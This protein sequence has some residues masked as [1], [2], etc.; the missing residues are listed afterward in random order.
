M[1]APS[2]D[3]GN[4]GSHQEFEANLRNSSN[5]LLALIERFQYFNEHFNARDTDIANKD[6]DHES[7]INR[8]NCSDHMRADAKRLECLNKCSNDR[9]R[10]AF[11]DQKHKPGTF[12]PKGPW[13]L[14]IWQLSR[15]SRKNSWK[16]LFSSIP[17]P[18]GRL[19]AVSSSVPS[20]DP[21]LTQTKRVFA[22]R[23]RWRRSSTAGERKRAVRNQSARG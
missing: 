20:P 15:P 7:K 10:K 4:K 23:R 22:T 17:L 9:V 18:L 1:S 2:T 6:G 5:D 13:W 11:R 21:P 19:S 3:V 16:H 8:S 14:I 12:V